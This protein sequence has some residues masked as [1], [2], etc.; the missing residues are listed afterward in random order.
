MTA[1]PSARVYLDWNATTPPLRAVLHAMMAAG[2]DAWANPSSVHGHGRLARA[3]VEDAR[4]AV[5]E[6]AGVDIRDVIFTAGGTEANNLAL[7]SPFVG[8][9]AP[10]GTLVTS[11]LEHPSVTRVAEALEREGR[12]KVRWLDVT[13]G[14]V[15]DLEDLDRALREGP[16][17]HVKLVAVQAVNHETGVVQPTHEIAAMAHAKGARVHVDAVQAFGRSRDVA[18]E[19]DTRSIAAHKL[20]GPKGVGALV[21]K[22]GARIEP[23]LLGG[24]QE[25]G[26][27]PGTVDPVAAAG[28]AVAAVHARTSPTRYAAVA[29]RRDRL[30]DALVALGGELNGAGAHVL[31]APH[32][33][34]VSWAGWVGAEM[35]AAIDL[36]G[37]SISSGSACSAGT[38]EPSPVIE[39]MLGTPRASSSVRISLGEE[40]TDADVDAC[41]AAF[42]RVLARGR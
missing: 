1:A 35:A 16:V 29:P 25:R 39:A 11:R 22:Q 20:R 4:A 40:T 14:G 17:G 32:V 3:R 38:I 27:R 31:R 23:V 6:L 9:G 19:A 15:V 5:A 10:V 7:R 24:A 18:P 8:A 26:L 33:V 21:L 12:A 28:F 13:R 41:I 30:A 2:T 42:E 34:S 37:V 36:E